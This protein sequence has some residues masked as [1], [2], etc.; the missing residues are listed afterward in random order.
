MT[1]HGSLLLAGKRGLDAP[2]EAPKTADII[3][4]IGQLK[5]RIT[6]VNRD[7]IGRLKV[8]ILISELH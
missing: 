3:N 1:V 6:L 4:K 2:S 7:K 8:M 5:A